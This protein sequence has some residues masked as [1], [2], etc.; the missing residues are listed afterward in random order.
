M[1]IKKNNQQVAE[2]IT[3]ANS[4]L[5]ELARPIAELHNE[6]AVLKARTETLEQDI[7][8]RDWIFSGRRP[9][10]CSESVSEAEQRR[11][12]L[13]FELK[14]VASRLGDLQR[15][16]TPLTR[17]QSQLR[18][19]LSH[20]EQAAITAEQLQPEIDTLEAVL[21]QLRSQ[22]TGLEKA[23][24]DNQNRLEFAGE[25]EQEAVDAAEQLK[26]ARANSFLAPPADK[27][28]LNEVCSKA[29]SALALAHEKALG[30]CAARPII[31]ARIGETKATLFAL[32]EQIEQQQNRLSE[33]R[34]QQRK[35]V[36][37]AE[38]EQIVE[39]ARVGLHN[40]LEA[41]RKVGRA[42]ADALMREGLKDFD[43]TGRLIRPQWLPSLA[44][45]LNSN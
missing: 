37:L 45:G 9:R 40:L 16:L 36:A 15:R 27:E 20:L 44:S 42:L 26:T 29:E 17:E 1:S 3:Q 23:L 22:R 33:K 28:A 8:A 35:L 18:C 39:Q 6:E 38:W 34:S 13:H 43:Y 10:G 41:D 4:R 11:R 21:A 19:E 24:E 5:S 30:A 31:N 2:E 12:Q 32:D 25:A 7:A 14:Q